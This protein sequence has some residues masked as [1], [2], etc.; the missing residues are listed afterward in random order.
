MTRADGR[1][2][3]LVRGRATHRLE[4]RLMGWNVRC[5]LNE[6]ASGDRDTLDGDD[7][8]IKEDGRR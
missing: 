6:R 8:L 1:S 4:C 5:M 2:P 7:W 3:S